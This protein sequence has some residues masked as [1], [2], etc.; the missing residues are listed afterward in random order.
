MTLKDV[1]FTTH[2]CIALPL[3]NIVLLTKPR[4]SDWRCNVRLFE[5]NLS[6][7]KFI[8]RVGQGQTMAFLATSSDAVALK[9]AITV[10]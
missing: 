7:L 5:F 3:I 4:Y 9:T 10:C 2:I 1:N 6:Y 8:L